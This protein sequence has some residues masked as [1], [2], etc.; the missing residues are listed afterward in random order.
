M[1]IIV[2]VKVQI[3]IANHKTQKRGLEFTL[4]SQVTICM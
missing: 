2:M 1:G 4:S 3:L